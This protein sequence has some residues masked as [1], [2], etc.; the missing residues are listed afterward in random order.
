MKHV[1]RN[2]I[3]FYLCIIPL[4]ALFACSKD[5]NANL[6]VYLLFPN[7]NRYRNLSVL[8]STTSIKYQNVAPLASKVIYD[9]GDCST[10]TAK[11]KKLEEV[12]CELAGPDANLLISVTYFWQGEIY[13]RT[14]NYSNRSDS[15]SIFNPDNWIKSSIP[16][17]G[18][19]IRIF[20]Y[21]Y[22]FPVVD[23]L[24]EDLI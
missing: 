5:N 21:Y 18:P 3:R 24:V 22:M 4:L 19:L 11:N 20:K 13:T 6:K 1:D 23:D 14:W 16:R 9:S 17:K 8:S 7:D 15:D 10:D 12:F 2:N